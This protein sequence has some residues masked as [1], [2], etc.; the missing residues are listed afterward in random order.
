MGKLSKVDA[1]ILAYKGLAGG[2]VA[3]VRVPRGAHMVSNGK[4]EKFRVSRLT[5]LAI[6]D[7][8]GAPQSAGQS[9]FFTN[10]IVMYPRGR[11]V[12]PNDFDQ[13]PYTTCGNGL[14]VCPTVSGAWSWASGHCGA[15][16]WWNK[17]PSRLRR[18]LRVA[19]QKA[20]GK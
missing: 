17:V 6:F 1:P 11:A 3:L 15:Y 2:L 5:V 13:D 19:R 18:A 4:R 9:P 16:C 12:R 8:D 7:R 10:R 20:E 14:H